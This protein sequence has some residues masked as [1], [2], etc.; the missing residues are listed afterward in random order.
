M[1][2]TFV[3]LT[4]SLLALSLFAQNQ[5]EPDLYI[6]EYK[7]VIDTL[8]ADSILKAYHAELHV[9]LT[10]AT[11]RPWLD[12]IA[13]IDK[14]IEYETSGEKI[15]EDNVWQYLMRKSKERRQDKDEKTISKR[16]MPKGFT[17]DVLLSRKNHLQ[18]LIDAYN[19]KMPSWNDVFYDHKQRYEYTDPERGTCYVFMDGVAL[20]KKKA[21]VPKP[22]PNCRDNYFNGTF[23]R[24]NNSSRP[25]FN[26]YEHEGEKWDG[27]QQSQGWEW[28]YTE[29]IQNE[30]KF[31]QTYFPEELGYHQHPAHPEYRLQYVIGWG[32]YNAFNEKGTL[33]RVDNMTK[34][35]RFTKYQDEVMDDILMQLCKRDFLANKYDINSAKPET[36]T[37]LRIRFDLADAVDAR[38]KKY[39]KM[40]QDARDEIVAATTPAQYAAA[41]KKQSEALNVLMEYVAKE[42]EPQAMNYIKQLKTDHQAELSYLYKI[43]R[44]DNVTF[45]LYFL[46]DKMECGCIALMKWSNKEPYEAQYEIEL[47]PI[48]K[49]IIRK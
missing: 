44:M 26:A 35:F 45:K 27:A 42:R 39:V 32:G 15:V 38:F 48:E 18:S 22:N 34:F 37:A 11:T 6:C 46:N 47:L 36:L 14:L 3:L 31:V 5:P 1:K 29:N 16:K 19:P 43:E 33:V 2:K 28:L 4:V 49:I 12:E 10:E 17:G 25:C 7:E 23:N 21:E 24:Y 13:I 8:L 40:A 20:P 9:K 41:K 30:T